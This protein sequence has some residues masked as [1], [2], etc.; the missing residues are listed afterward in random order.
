MRQG[1]E[2]QITQ[3]KGNSSELSYTRATTEHKGPI[4]KLLVR[5]GQGCIKTRNIAYLNQA[6]S[7]LLSLLACWTAANL[8]LLLGPLP[9]P[10]PEAAPVKASPLLFP[11][12]GAPPTPPAPPPALVDAA[13]VAIA[14]LPCCTGSSLEKPGI[15]MLWFIS[16][17]SWRS[18]ISSDSL[19]RCFASRHAKLVTDSMNSSAISRRS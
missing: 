11:P 9:P 18:L 10:P 12:A 4:S 5:V 7:N 15:R 13:A 17:C 3:R 2:L 6:Q 16:R 8:A 19:P 1:I 14:T